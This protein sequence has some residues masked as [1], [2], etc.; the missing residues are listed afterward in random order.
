MKENESNNSAR[1]LHLIKFILLSFLFI[2]Y[3][4]ESYIITNQTRVFENSSFYV[5]FVL[6]QK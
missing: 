5:N 6:E 1:K 3:V 2:S 4:N